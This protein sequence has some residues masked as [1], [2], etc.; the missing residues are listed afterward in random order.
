MITQLKS[1][2]IEEAKK[3]A[4]AILEAEKN[5]KTIPDTTVIPDTP[6][7]ANVKSLQKEVDGI[8]S[9]IGDIKN[10]IIEMTKAQYVNKSVATAPQP[11]SI[12]VD[13]TVEVKPKVTQAE[14][15]AK[16]IADAPEGLRKIVAEELSAKISGIFKI[17]V[18]KRINDSYNYDIDI[19]VPDEFAEVK[20][21]RDCRSLTVSGAEGDTAVRNHCIR[22]RTHIANKLMNRGQLIDENLRNEVMVMKAKAFSMNK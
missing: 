18:R 22:I 8:K 19:F 7:H 13:D 14:K 5:G 3:E 20:G 15:D 2:N 12:P 11:V 17:G 6:K 9:D 10:L 4:E 21:T 1:T 16:A